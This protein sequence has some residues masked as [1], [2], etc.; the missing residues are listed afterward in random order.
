MSDALP[1]LKDSSVEA[2]AELIRVR[3]GTER[4][5][6]IGDLLDELVSRTQPPLLTLKTDPPAP[7]LRD[8]RRKS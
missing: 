7:R 8:T 3:V 4:A 1:G 5:K 2:I 6:R